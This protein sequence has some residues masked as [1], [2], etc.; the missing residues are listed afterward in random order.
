MAEFI[1]FIQNRFKKFY[2]E[3]DE[4][5][6]P[7]FRF[8]TAFFI[9]YVLKN[10]IG[11]N[12]SVS[13]FPVI[14]VISLIC[15]FLPVGAVSV[16]AAGFVLLNMYKTSLSMALV[17]CVFLMVI[18]VIFFGLRPGKGIIFSLMS[19]C[20]ILKIPYVIPLVLA[21]TAGISGIVPMISGIGFWYVIRYFHMNSDNM[22]FV[23]DPMVI[24]HEFVDIVSTIA[25]DRSLILYLAAFMAGLCIV[26]LISRTGFNYCRETAI[27]SG[28][29]VML[30]ILVA[31]AAYFPVNLDFAAVIVGTVL[32]VMIA[33][34]Y[35]LFVFNVDY[36][37]KQYVSFED[38]DYF[39]FVKAL[40]KIKE[41]EE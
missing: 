14:L 13:R 35:E 40:P 6:L 10:Y 33:L 29:A 21:F 27:I 15:A 11:L 17:T 25:D 2:A 4:F 36:R 30:L 7:V 22:Q 38:D 37:G 24:V 8:F 9:L 39:Y 19:V 5:I 1:A 31:G 26:L 16:F 3:Y 18:M 20:F 28:A 32:S 12:P 23:K 34:L 41:R